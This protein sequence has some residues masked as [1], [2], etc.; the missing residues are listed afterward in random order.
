MRHSPL[1]RTKAPRHVLPGFVRK[2]ARSHRRPLVLTALSLARER[3]DV[4][5][6]DQAIFEILGWPPVEY[7][8]EAGRQSA[9]KR[10]R[11]M[12]KEG[13]SRNLAPLAKAI[14]ERFVALC[15]AFGLSDLE[16]E[17][18]AFAVW[19][20][21]DPLLQDALT[22]VVA[23]QR[24]RADRQLAQL[25]G[26]TIAAAQ[27]V[28]SP[29]SGVVRLGLIAEINIPDAAAIRAA[30]RVVEYL[31]NSKADLGSVLASVL[32]PTPPPNLG[33]ANYPHLL[34][35]SRLAL[36][37]LGG[38]RAAQVL[39]HG[40]PGMGKTE[41]ARVLAAEA[42]L[43][44]YEVGAGSDDEPLGAEQRWQTLN[45][46]QL[47][48][49]RRTAPIALLVDE[50]DELLA[51]DRGWL[52]TRPPVRKLWRNQMLEQAHVPI[53]WITNSVEAIDAA[54]LRR[55]DLIVRMTAPPLVV[56]RAMVASAFASSGLSTRVMDAIASQPR[57]S[58]AEL[59][60]AARL[61]QVV[62][63]GR[64]GVTT[65]DAALGFLNGIAQATQRERIVLGRRQHF[66]YRPEWVNS[67]PSLS[68]L[69]ERIPDQGAMCLHGP[70][71]TGKTAFARMIADELGRDGPYPLEWSQR[72]VET[73]TLGGSHA[74]IEVQRKPDRRG[75]E[76]GGGGSRRGDAHAQTRHQRCDV[77]P[78]ACEV[79]RDERFGHAAPA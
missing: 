52:F 23:R 57:T 61:A 3:F 4:E 55:F 37:L 50:A 1:Q 64:G 54:L 73:L 29:R 45:L 21:A 18:L 42:G 76:G 67:T 44:L 9:Q 28:L 14:G 41:L 56:R 49:A 51:D 75:A 12:L 17:L 6:A 32:Q 35:E 46:A 27:A 69:L 47:A 70:P 43:T 30:P 77:L 25:L 39:L 66:P 34:R 8:S 26:V 68:S 63:S 58:P 24:G 65:D 78:V 72:E 15:E 62:A 74:Q 31:A 16:S 7:G 10:A 33:L 22:D 60:A 40:A 38:G 71:G 79:R 20:A 53:V 48:A 5:D 19:L 36:A 13:G 2:L 11:Q 59:A